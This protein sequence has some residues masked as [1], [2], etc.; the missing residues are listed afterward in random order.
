M[1]DHVHEFAWGE[2]TPREEEDGVF[3]AI[4]CKVCELRILATSELDE[5]PGTMEWIAGVVKR[6]ESEE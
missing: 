5:S 3:R 6:L 2:V 4:V 1:A